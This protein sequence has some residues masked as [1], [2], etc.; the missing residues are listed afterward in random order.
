MQ[1]IYQSADDVIVFMG[2]GRSH[3][4]ERQNLMHPPASPERRFHG[5]GRDET[6]IKEFRGI[7]ESSVTIEDLS[8]HVSFL[9]MGLGRLLSDEH[10]LND[11]YK[12]LMALR[13]DIR[14]ELFEHLRNF[15]V[16]PWWQRIWVVQEVAVSSAVVVQYGTTAASWEVFSRAAQV[17]SRE[18]IGTT[19]LAYQ[20]VLESE[21]SK[22]LT[23]LKR[24]LLSLEG[25]RRRWN[26]EGGIEL[27]RLLQEFSVRKASDD[28]DKVYGLLSLAKPGHF[29]DADYSH[30]VLHT[31]RMVALELI[32]A[33]TS[34]SCWSGDQ[35]RKDHKDLPS[36][37]PD[38]ST[39]YHAADSRRMDLRNA[40]DVSCG[41]KLQ[42]I[43]NETEYWVSVEEQMRRLGDS[44]ERLPSE[45]R[46]CLPAWLLPK[47]DHYKDR[48]A[49]R[50]DK[51]DLD[52]KS[53]YFQ[54]HARRVLHRLKKAGINIVPPSERI[55]EHGLTQRTYSR[56][57]GS[58]ASSFI[59]S[60]IYPSDTSLVDLENAGLCPRPNIEI[61]TACSDALHY[62]AHR[63]LHSTLDSKDEVHDL[64]DDLEL[65]RYLGQYIEY[66]KSSHVYVPFCILTCSL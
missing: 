7:L 3:R 10:K 41:W 32:R 23:L 16:S 46:N 5:D 18:D 21:N 17:L 57:I 56:L 65:L 36:W 26:T 40:Y 59:E 12:F 6:L 30:D 53:E 22:V 24:Q 62:L 64:V 51:V 45:H 35:R 15:L 2:D 43:S 66:G 38:W 28:R 50:F 37:V 27:I 11:A 29:I 63:I 39:T 49:R 14:W 61:D 33:D 54:Y 9:I 8:T 42:Y 58:S 31:Y 44:L 4:V 47:I 20:S 48:V 52:S 1:K 13:Q 60:S 55:A 19:D 25:T 34:L